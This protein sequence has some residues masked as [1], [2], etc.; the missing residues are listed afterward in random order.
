MRK[1]GREGICDKIFRE[2][3]SP[4]SLSGELISDESFYK[5]LDSARFAPSS[6]NEQEWRYV[7]SKKPNWS[8]LFELLAPPNQ[9]W[10][11]DA[12]HL[13]LVCARSNYTRNNK[14][15]RVAS[16]DVGLSVQNMLLQASMIGLVGHPMGG[17]DI[18][19][20]RKN[21]KIPDHFEVLIMIAF[22]VYKESNEIPSERKP[23]EDVINEGGFSFE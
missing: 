6:F 5:I 22:G 8:A 7:W 17:F 11:K 10:C 15:N 20:A 23:L 14:L 3:W 4:R 18:E 9:E 21:L 1:A 16:F 19:L 12:S 13:V 2:R